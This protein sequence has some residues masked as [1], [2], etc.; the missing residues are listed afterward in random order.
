M[1]KQSLF[2]FLGVLLS[3]WKEGEMSLFLGDAFWSF[4]GWNALMSET[5]EEKIEENAVCGAAYW[6]GT[7][8]A[9]PF[10]KRTALQSR[11]TEPQDPHSR[12]LGPAPP[13]SGL[14]TEFSAAFSSHT[15]EPLLCAGAGFPLWRCSWEHAGSQ[16]ERCSTPWA[17]YFLQAARQKGRP[18]LWL[19]PARFSWQAFPAA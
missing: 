6:Q 7:H 2:I 12:A 17:P 19:N 16:G 11:P 18:E 15:Q 9:L 14:G 13:D 1:A 3:Y 10:C 5:W 4:Q 8:E